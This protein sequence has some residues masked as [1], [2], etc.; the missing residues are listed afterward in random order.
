MSFPELSNQT[1]LADELDLSGYNYREYFYEQ[2]HEKYPGRVILGSENS[3]QASCWYAVTDHDYIAGQFLWTGIDFLGECKGW[4]VR[5]S[6]AGLL[7]LT[8]APKPLYY[9]R[10]AL[11]TD[12][13]KLSSPCG[14]QRESCWQRRKWMQ[15]VASTPCLM[16]L[17]SVVTC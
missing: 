15:V 1:G 8:G 14:V 10:K 17:A 5:I 7:K 6:Q 12:V 4:P 11:W 9:Q 2:D 3:H 16:W 13:Q